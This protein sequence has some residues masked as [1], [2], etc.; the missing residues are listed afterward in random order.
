MQSIAERGR[1]LVAI[2]LIPTCLY[3]QSWV[4]PKFLSLIAYVVYIGILYNLYLFHGFEDVA[5]FLF[6][7]LVLVEFILMVVDDL[8]VFDEEERV[9]RNK[10]R[11]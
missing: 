8:L 2:A 10:D 4:I 11:N 1:L 9:S 7:V 3:P 6:Q 5:H